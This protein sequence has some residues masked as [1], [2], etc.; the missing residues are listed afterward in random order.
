MDKR[1]TSRFTLR[2]GD[3]WV[4][5]LSAVIRASSLPVY[6]EAVASVGVRRLMEAASSID[7]PLLW[8][9]YSNDDPNDDLALGNRFVDAINRATVSKVLA[10]GTPLRTAE[11][12]FARLI[13]LLGPFTIAVCG[14]HRV[15]GHLA[16]MESFHD[17]L[18]RVAMIGGV[19]DYSGDS[20]A[21]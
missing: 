1:S 7:R 20:G 8:V 18:N 5:R 6:I 10:N 19:A 17:G 14:A 15:A 21:E 2:S 9:D 13:G 12:A 3:P 4:D 16:R 11:D